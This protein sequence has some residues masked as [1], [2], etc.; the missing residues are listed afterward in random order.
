MGEEDTRAT[1]I[2]I[3]SYREAQEMAEFG[4]IITWSPKRSQD[5][6]DNVMGGSSSAQPDDFKPQPGNR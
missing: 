3:K 5:L 2:Q 1:P 6:C 4:D